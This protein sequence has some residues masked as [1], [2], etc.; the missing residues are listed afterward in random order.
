MV[1]EKKIKLSVKSAHSGAA[2]VKVYRKIISIIWL[3][4]YIHRHFFGRPFKAV[5][6]EL[7]IY[8]GRT[9]GIFLILVRPL[10]M[11]SVIVPFMYIG[12]YGV[13]TGKVLEY[14]HF[15]IIIKSGFRSESI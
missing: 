10:S 15:D 4:I 12:R 6:M 9:E 3:I 13:K 14:I 7:I 8:I 11:L 5:G 1:V 2:A